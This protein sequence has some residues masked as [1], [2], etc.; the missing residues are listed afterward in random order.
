MKRIAWEVFLCLIGVIVGL[1]AAPWFNDRVLPR[2]RAP[3]A[4]L[5]LVTSPPLGRDAI[6]GVKTGPVLPDHKLYVVVKSGDRYW[7]QASLEHH[8]NVEVPVALGAIG[9][10]DI[11]G[12]F[13]VQ[14]IDAFGPADS[15]MDDYFVDLNDPASP[16]RRRG[17]SLTRFDNNIKRLAVMSLKREW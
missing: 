15:L 8:S 5:S 2:I 17:M 12:V 9:S 1:V 7:P 11:G 14:V 3:H 16:V 10:A 6:I 4:E 13:E